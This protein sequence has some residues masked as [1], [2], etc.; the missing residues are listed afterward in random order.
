[1]YVPGELEARKLKTVTL[2][3]LYPSRGFDQD[4]GSIHFR[5]AESQFHRLLAHGARMKVQKGMIFPKI[6]DDV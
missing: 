2:F 3:P 4:A 6:N 1:M 5:I